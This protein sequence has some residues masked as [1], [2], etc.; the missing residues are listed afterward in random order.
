MTGPP[1]SRI[2]VQSSSLVL[3]FFVLLALDGPAG[4]AHPLK[5]ESPAALLLEARGAAASIDDTAGRSA[6]L[7]P[8]VVAQI[9]IDPPGA[10]DTLKVFP[11]S[12]KKLQYLTALAAAYAETGNIAE[13]ERMYAEIVV[14]DQSSRLGKLAAAN[15]L[16]Q[17]AIAYA[18]KGNIE[19]AS[20]TLS[21]LK[22]RLKD[23]PLPI[24]IRIATSK[25][26]EAQA[27]QGDIRGALQTGLTII[28]ENPVPFMTIIRDRV[29]SGRVQEVQN[30]IGALDERAQQYAQWGIMQ[31]QI[32]Q[33]RLTDAQVTASAIKPGHAKAGALLELATYHLQHG[34]NPLALVLLQEAEAS[35]RMT[36]NTLTPAESLQH[37]AASTAMGGDAAR[38]TTIARSIE[39]EGLRIAAL[40]DIVN[41]QAKRREFAGAFNTATLLKQAP[42]SNALTMS[43]YDTA[44]SD[45]LVELVKAGKGME[46]KDTVAKFQDTDISRSWLYSGISAIQADM[47]NIK[48]AEAVLALAETKGQRSARRKE[49][50]QVREKIRLGQNPTDETRLQELWKVEVEIQ[51][52]LDAIAKALARKGDLGGAMAVADELNQPAHRLDLIKELSTLHVQTGRKEQTVR[53]ARNLSRSPE[54]VFALVGIA[55]ALSQADKQK[56]KPPP[57]KKAAL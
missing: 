27:K 11:R 13:T 23:E 21:R 3:V 56:A 10:R 7:D 1:T 4:A 57:V 38:A 48:E 44:I 30:I 12:P 31:A 9:A 5:S 35:A 20:R 34:T 33:G 22:E 8:I 41:A 51:R 18:I 42:R 37:I 19:E 47:G 24:I 54:K 26:V 53:W 32:Q 28:E 40:H 36:A 2:P 16:G 17:I 15:A 29:R 14:E 50:V 45:I 43:D 39:N 49:L 6:A 55:V 46:A 52:G 25:L